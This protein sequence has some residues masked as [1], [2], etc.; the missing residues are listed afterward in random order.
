MAERQETTIGWIDILWLLFLGGLAV[1]PPIREPH[2]QF[3]LL[4]IGGFQL[5]EREL[6]AW[7]PKR[8]PY[9]LVELAWPAVPVG[10]GHAQWRP[11]LGIGV[12]ELRHA[13]TRR[14]YL[15]RELSHGGRL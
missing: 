7:F 14:G 2:K 9:Y 10:T 5:F 3:T 6:L 4:A 1:L 11:I 8:A 15:Q 12:R 13:G